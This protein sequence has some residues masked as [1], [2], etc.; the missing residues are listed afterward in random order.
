MSIIRRGVKKRKKNRVSVTEGRPNSAVILSC[1]IVYTLH[2]PSK[3]DN[4]MLSLII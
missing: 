4:T 2:K 3:I 1:K